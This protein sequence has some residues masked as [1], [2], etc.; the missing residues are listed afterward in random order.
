MFAPLTVHAQANQQ[1]APPSDGMIQDQA[2]IGQAGLPYLSIGAVV[3]SI[4]KAVLGL[5]GIIFIVLIIYAGLLW[6]TSAGDE[7][8]I[9]KAKKIMA[10]S[11]I[12]LVITLSAYAITI[13]VIDSIFRSPTNVELF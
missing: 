12:G 2:F 13:F 8:K 1:T 7:D 6:M 5:I 9:E 10:A 11:L 4:I 3:A